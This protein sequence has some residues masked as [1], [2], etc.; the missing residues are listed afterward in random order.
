MAKNDINDLMLLL[1]VLLVLLVVVALEMVL[2][3]VS[4]CSEV[5]KVVLVFGG[6]YFNFWVIAK[7]DVKDSMLSL[8]LVMVEE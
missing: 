5:F 8:L 1:V 7:N 6:D 4:F 3:S 2:V